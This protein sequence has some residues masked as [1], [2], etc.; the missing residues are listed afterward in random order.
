MIGTA[1]GRGGGSGRSGQREQSRESGQSGQSGGSGRGVPRGTTSR[2]A[3]PGAVGRGWAAAGALLFA[4]VAW[5]CGDQASG[6]DWTGRIDTLAGGGVRVVNPSTGV[7]SE[8]ERWRLREELRLG[9][10]EGDGPEIFGRVLDVLAGP[11]GR[12]YMLERPSQELRIFAPD[13]SHVATA[14]GPGQ[15]PGELNLTFLGQLVQAP[16]G[17]IW[18]NNATS[19]RWEVFT[20]EGDFVTS[21]PQRLNSFSVLNVAGDDGTLYVGDQLRDPDGE[22]R[23][24]VIHHEMR[25][26]SLVALDTFPVPELPERESVDVSLSSDD[27]QIDMRVPVPFVHQPGWSLDPGGHFWVE[28][29]DGYRL[30][31]VG[32]EGDTLRVVERAYEPVP[33]TAAE[34]DRA[35]EP[36]ETGELASADLDRSRVPDHHP[37]IDRY[38]T[39]PAGNLWVRR[40][41]GEDRKALD[42]FD[43][44]GIY[45]GEVRTDIDLDRFTLEQITDDAVYGVLRDELDVQY[46]LRLAIEKDPEPTGTG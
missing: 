32:L 24:I 29:G 30:V 36:Y 38:W 45:L 12:I 25:G 23:Q 1:I 21:V 39:D 16:S 42:V 19:R 33:V 20:Q 34:L 5:S 28:P 22:S 10:I 15:G 2:P 3:R 41:V 7:W 17:R 40:V 9:T 46:I 4:S 6:R 35:M 26:D 13:G 18:V 43:P 8:E 31:A 37:A 44:E 11:S 27:T 14:G